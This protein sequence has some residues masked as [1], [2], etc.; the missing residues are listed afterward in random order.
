MLQNTTARLVCDQRPGAAAAAAALGRGR[1]GA[2]VVAVVEIRATGAAEEE[3]RE[4]QEDAADQ[5]AHERQR[6]EQLGQR[7]VVVDVA[8]ARRLLAVRAAAPTA[9]A[10]QLEQPGVD[11]RRRDHAWFAENFPVAVLG[12]VFMQTLRKIMQKFYC[13]GIMVCIFEKVYTVMV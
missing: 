7:L 3:Q 5:L 4:E 8:R 6:D 1:L 12:R 9:Q 2:G 11:H 13:K 10:R